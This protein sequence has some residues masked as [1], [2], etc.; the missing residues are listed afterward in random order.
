MGIRAADNRF[1]NVIMDLELTFFRTHCLEETPIASRRKHKRSD[2]KPRPYASLLI[3]D[4]F[5]HHVGLA[6]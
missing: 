1:P 5:F 6:S 2:V 3:Q 4:Q